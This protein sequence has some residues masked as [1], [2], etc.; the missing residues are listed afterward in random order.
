M[1]S[2][3]NVGAGAPVSTRGLVLS[4]LHEEGVESLTLLGGLWH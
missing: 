2:L 3:K 1:S 4:C